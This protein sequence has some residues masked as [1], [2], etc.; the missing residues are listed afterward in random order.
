MGSGLKFWPNLFVFVIDNIYQLLRLLLKSDGYS[1][2]L[3]KWVSLTFLYTFLRKFTFKLR[4]T[5][6]SLRSLVYQNIYSLK[7]FLCSIRF[8]HSESH[9][10]FFR[11]S[12]FSFVSVFNSFTIVQSMVESYYFSI[13]LLSQPQ[14]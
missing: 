14:P 3:Q 9:S 5:L 12:W 7:V 13:V 8:S 6:L 4:L 10:S 11:K 2:S 1:L